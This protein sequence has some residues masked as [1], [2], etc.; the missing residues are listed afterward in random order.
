M[1]LTRLNFLSLLPPLGP[2]ANDGYSR[3]LLRRDCRHIPAAKDGKLPPP[4]CPGRG[5][6]RGAPGQGE[7]EPQRGNAGR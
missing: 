5:R 4:P 6:G 2:A 1:H 7:P 3:N